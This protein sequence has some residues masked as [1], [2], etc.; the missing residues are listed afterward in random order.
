MTTVDARDYASLYGPT[1]GDRVRLADTDLWVEVEADDTE[2]GEELIG[3]CG[4]TARLGALVA[5]GGGRTSALDLVVLGV[6]L[7]DPVLGV[8]KTSIG[9]KDGRVVGVGRAGNPDVQQGVE[10]VVDAH[11][12]MIPGEGLIATP[13]VVDSHVHMSNADLAAAAL[14]AGVTTI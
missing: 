1:T 13:G 8:R 4:K 14:S 2:P 11:T 12:A 5:P 3:G 7:I 9:V 10:L 6:L